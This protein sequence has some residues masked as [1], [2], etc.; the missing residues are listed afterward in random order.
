M[1]AFT[2][3]AVRF[4]L[5]GA[6]L[7][8]AARVRKGRAAWRIERP[9]VRNAA[10]CGALTLAGGNGVLVLA[11]TRVP[12]GLAALLV[13]V[14]PLWLVLLRRFV[15]DRTPA[16]TLAGVLVGLAGV[17]LLLLP[18]SGGKHFDVAYAALILL[19][20]L[21][22][23]MGSLLVTRTTVPD[24]PAMLS[25]IEMVAGGAVLL[26]AAASR[27]EFARLHLGDISTK[28]WLSLA[29]LVVFGSI[30]AFSAYLYALANAPTSLVATYAYVNPVVAVALGVM[31]AG[32]HL[33]SSEVAG[34]L[35][36]VASVVLVVSAEG[37]RRRSAGS[38]Q[39][40]VEVIADDERVVEPQ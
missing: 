5:A 13:A 10:V 22:W 23:S 19:A 3:A 30:V 8:V 7:G 28:S 26:V 15:G 9:R 21:S 25:S 24:E 38:A 33:T 1:P 29:Y 40:P 6:I 11:E 35:V 34:G 12:S 20:A 16:L 32:E 18:G 39:R 2:S 31:L 4:L 17:A 36:I 27:G 14:V 37:R